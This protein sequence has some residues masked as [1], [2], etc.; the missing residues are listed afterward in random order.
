MGV[1]LAT[2]IL[3]QTGSEQWI[4]QGCGSAILPGW[5]WVELA[6]AAPYWRPYCSPPH[7]CAGAP[8]PSGPGESHGHL[9]Q[10]PTTEGPFCA[11]HPYG[12]VKSGEIQR[13]MA[14]AVMRVDTPL[15]PPDDHPYDAGKLLVLSHPLDP[16]AC[17]DCADSSGHGE[18]IQR[19]VHQGRRDR[20]VR[21]GSGAS[22]SRFDRAP[23]IRLSD[24]PVTAGTRSPF[25]PSRSS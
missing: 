9:V 10:P 21:A 12:E 6:S 25:F 7:L 14:M 5:S 2:A 8:R 3:S 22:G 20:L 13:S 1:D 24:S 18:A 17:G 23:C 19:P 15:A 4:F 16:P 11:N